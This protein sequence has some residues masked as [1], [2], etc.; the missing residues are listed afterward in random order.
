[1]LDS[2]TSLDT[3][4]TLW[5]N[6]S[7]SLWLDGFAMAVTSTLTWVPAALVLIYVIIRHGEMKEIL[8][9]ILA[10]GLCVLVADQIA[11]GLFK[12]L[13]ARP[14]PANDPLIMLQVDVVN[15][16]RG[17]RYGFFSSHA[18]NTFAITTFVAL[19]MR[20]RALTISMASWAL[21]NC[22]SRV[23]LG[24]HYVGDIVCGTLC[25]ILV[26]WLIYKGYCRVVK[27]YRVSDTGRKDTLTRSGY[28]VAD[29][30]LLATTLPVLYVVCC[31]LALLF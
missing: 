19:L 9:T 20:Y 15:D 30:R 3:A 17:G 8:L 2:L 31:F 6:G 10:I 18:A 1:M 27:T 26:G 24:V 11:S 12:P 16:Y 23:Y 25:G 28:D 21:L 5:L 22:W 13:V 4:L 14:R 7:D 29:T